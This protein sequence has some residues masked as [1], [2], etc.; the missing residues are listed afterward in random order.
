MALTCRFL[1]GP[2]PSPYRT[3]FVN[4]LREAIKSVAATYPDRGYELGSTVG[5]CDSP[6]PLLRARLL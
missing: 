6:D 1:E 4:Q 3:P 5:D 2:A